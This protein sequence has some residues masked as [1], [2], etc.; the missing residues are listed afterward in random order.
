MGLYMLIRPWLLC[1]LHS[2]ISEQQVH[3]YCAGKE[4]RAAL[5]EQKGQ[6]V[7]GQSHLLS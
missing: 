1:A 5:A 4:K 6:L 2:D 7:P 3:C